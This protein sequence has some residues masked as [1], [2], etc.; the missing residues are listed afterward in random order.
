MSKITTV[1]APG[2]RGME[3]EPLAAIIS[4]AVPDVPVVA[5]GSDIEAVVREVT[6]EAKKEDAVVLIFGSLS[7]AKTVYHM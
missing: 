3:D 7:M 4:G 1:R 6:D 2:E 5:G